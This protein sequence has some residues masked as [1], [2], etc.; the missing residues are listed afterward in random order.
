M[1]PLRAPF[2]G[3]R[4]F[5]SLCLEQP[6]TTLAVLKSC[7]VFYIQ[8]KRKL[9]CIKTVNWNGISIKL[10]KKRSQGSCKV[11]KNQLNRHH[12]SL[13]PI[14]FY[15]NTCLPAY[16]V[17]PCFNYVTKNRGIIVWLPFQLGLQTSPMFTFE[18]P[19]WKECISNRGAQM[20]EHEERTDGRSGRGRIS[21]VTAARGETMSGVWF[22]SKSK[23]CTIHFW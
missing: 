3:F 4:T 13:L 1:I 23:T 5:L 17:C 15:S 21:Y 11:G 12:Q 22:I 14:L 6:A 9:Q 16:K 7:L 10:N 2:N 20:K 18:G 8:A 19:C